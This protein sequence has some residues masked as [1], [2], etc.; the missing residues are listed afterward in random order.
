[1]STTDQVTQNRAHTRFCFTA[2]ANHET[3][4]R[5]PLTEA[6]MKIFNLLWA[7][8]KPKSITVRLGIR[9]QGVY[10]AIGK[11]RECGWELPPREEMYERG[12]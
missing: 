2:Q 3:L 5:K 11:I 10:E 8:W 12:K 6:Q 9:P 7:G 1:M 4:G